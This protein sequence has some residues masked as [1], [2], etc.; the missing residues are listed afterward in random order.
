MIIKHKGAVGTHAE[1]RRITHIEHNGVFVYVSTAGRHK[2][3]D[4][5]YIRI[6]YDHWFETMV[7]ICDEQFG[8]IAELERYTRRIADFDDCDAAD[9]QHDSIVSEIKDR[10]E[11]GE[12]FTAGVD[13]Y[14]NE[15]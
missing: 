5:E 4:G 6:G 8:R 3:R 2:D 14:S 10:L 11:S 7:W 12:G 1:F 9:D 13:Y 15:D